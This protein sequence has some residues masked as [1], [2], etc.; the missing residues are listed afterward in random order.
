MNLIQISRKKSSVKQYDLLIQYK[1]L[2]RQI[3]SLFYF[4]KVLNN[5]SLGE[6]TNHPNPPSLRCAILH[7]ESQI[8]NATTLF[9]CRFQFSPDFRDRFVVKEIYYQLNNK[10]A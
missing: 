10:K 1:S 7:S 4:L 8:F 5:R 3:S 2:N 6:H 9:L